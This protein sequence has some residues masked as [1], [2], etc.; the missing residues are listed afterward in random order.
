MTTPSKYPPHDDMYF[1]STKDFHVAPGKV[2]QNPHF[3]E[4]WKT[5][6]IYC[7]R[8]GISGTYLA[9]NLHNRPHYQ[10]PI[11]KRNH[12]KTLADSKK[13]DFHELDSNTH[14]DVGNL[15]HNT[16]DSEK[17]KQQRKLIQLFNPKEVAD[18]LFS[19]KKKSRSVGSISRSAGWVSLHEKSKE[20]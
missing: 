2:K 11:N 4:L 7:V 18:F 17:Y 3:C 10:F 5:T 8:S 6:D 1:G 19:T 12:L 20:S 16:N 15:I 14:K 9:W 13:N